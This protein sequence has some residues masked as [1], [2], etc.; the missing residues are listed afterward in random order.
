MYFIIA[1]ESYCNTLKVTYW[2]ITLHS[3]RLIIH[4]LATW[5]WTMMCWI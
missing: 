1:V 5:F 4:V 3:S 2:H